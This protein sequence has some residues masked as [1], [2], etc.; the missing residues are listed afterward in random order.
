MFTNVSLFN[1]V[2][3]KREIALFI[4][5]WTIFTFQASFTRNYG[6]KFHI[7][8]G[9]PTRGL[10]SLQ[11]LDQICSEYATPVQEQGAKT[12]R[13]KFMITCMYSTDMLMPPPLCSSYLYQKYAPVK[14]MHFCSLSISISMSLSL[15]LSLP[16]LPA[17]ACPC[18][19]PFI[20]VMKNNT[21]RVQ[22]RI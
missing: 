5:W 11:T 15:S 19:P 21:C 22:W 13:D 4:S 6:W 7:R 17:R 14:G 8:V 20:A 10:S 12:R 18:Q 9:I 16:L 2:I 3:G 1:F